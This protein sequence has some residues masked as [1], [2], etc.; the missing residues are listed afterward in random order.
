MAE[1][2]VRYRTP[3]GTFDTYE[4]AAEACERCDFDPVLC[5]E[6]LPVTI[7]PFEKATK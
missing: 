2:S 3:V 7:T 4:E 6:I 5:V 1:S